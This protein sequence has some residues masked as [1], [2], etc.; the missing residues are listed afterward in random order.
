MDPAIAANA[1]IAA[2][3]PKPSISH[4]PSGAITIVP[5]DPAAATRPTVWLRFSG[6]VAREMVPIR[7]PK[8]APA[9]PMPIR[10]PAT[11]KPPGM[12]FET[13]ISKSPKAYS[14]AVTI[15]TGPRAVAVGERADEGLRHAPDD[16]LQRD[17]EAE[18]RRR[19][20]EVER[21]RPHEQAQALAQA[22]AEGDDQAAQHDE[23]QH[24]ASIAWHDVYR[25]VYQ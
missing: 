16:V 9:V 5:S 19:D 7:T 23:Q 6:G 15:S 21:H 11:S 13:I 24:S 2:C 17:R 10:K 1:S 25:S 4:P 22:H 3:Q 12:L 8:P 14:R 18:G 20:P